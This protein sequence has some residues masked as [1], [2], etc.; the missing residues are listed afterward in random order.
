M[1]SLENVFASSFLREYCTWFMS[2]TYKYKVSDIEIG[3]VI[4]LDLERFCCNCAPFC[5]TAIDKPE[6]GANRT[7]HGYMTNM[8]QRYV[9]TIELEEEF[10]CCGNFVFPDDWKEEDAR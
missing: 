4:I 7:I 10:S 8:N 5:V 6:N 2:D 9:I 1:L 3:D